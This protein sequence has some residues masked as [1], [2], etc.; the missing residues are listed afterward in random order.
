MEI[1]VV[2]LR[3]KFVAHLAKSG[4]KLVAHPAEF[5]AKW[6]FEILRW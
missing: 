1:L 5:G 2:K 3:A 6:K 4:A